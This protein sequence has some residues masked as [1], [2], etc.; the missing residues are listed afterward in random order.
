M[1]PKNGRK[2]ICELSVEKHIKTNG[3]NIP[4]DKSKGEW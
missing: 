1:M 4:V 3:R 2:K